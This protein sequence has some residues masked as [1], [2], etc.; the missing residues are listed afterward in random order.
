V[1]H[2]IEVNSES[3]VDDVDITRDSQPLSFLDDIIVT[4]S[5]GTVSTTVDDSVLATVKRSLVGEFDG[6]SKLEGKRSLR[7]VKVK[8]EKE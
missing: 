4:P 5:V 6:V 3:E 2:A 1:S 8:I 7:R